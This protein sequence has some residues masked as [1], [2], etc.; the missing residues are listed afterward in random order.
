MK[1]QLLEIAFQLFCFCIPRTLLQLQKINKSPAGARF[2]FLKIFFKISR[3]SAQCFG[4]CPPNYTYATD[5]GDSEHS[6]EK[7]Y[8]VLY[9]V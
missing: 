8:E 6:E 7:V 1:N 3:S 9:I 2:F 5:F 4:R